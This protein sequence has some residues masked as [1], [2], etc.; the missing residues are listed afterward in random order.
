MFGRSK[1]QAYFLRR[2]DSWKVTNHSN[3]KI[4]ETFT[5]NIQDKNSII[6]FLP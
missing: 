1:R 2:L 6:N 4:Y 3:G 5:V